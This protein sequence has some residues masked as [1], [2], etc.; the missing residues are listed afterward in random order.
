MT[1][2]PGIFQIFRPLRSASFKAVCA[3][4]IQGVAIDSLLL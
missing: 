4:K 2:F 1:H 3:V